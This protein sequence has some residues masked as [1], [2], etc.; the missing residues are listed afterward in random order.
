MKHLRTALGTALA[1]LV[2][3]ATPAHAI[4]FGQPDG[5]RHPSVGALLHDYDPAS[6]GPDV[7]CTGT[8]IAPK[9]FLTASHCTEGLDRVAVSFASRYDEGA[10]DP[11]GVIGG[12]AVTH[13]EYGTGGQ[14]DGHDIAV[15]LLDSAPAGI[16][17]AQ[18]PARRSLD[19]LKAAHA[20]DD[21]TFTA[22]GY[23]LVRD[24]KGG[25]SKELYD[26]MGERRFALQTSLSLRENWLLLSM[27]PATGDG[28]TCYGDSGGPHF[29]GGER[30]DRIVSITVTGDAV[31][32]ATDKTYRL[33]SDSAR[34]FLD[35][36]VTL[37]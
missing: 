17:P 20:L 24:T 21:Q 18:L 5:D 32:R 11:A 25:G 15:V 35:D 22:V 27:N 16:T 14:D 6:P 23:G 31:C 36:Y 9:V 29:L 10:A 7:M 26:P 19:R 13:P 3:T 30:S 28:G 12:R 8:L 4:T 33:D 34:A 2:V 37:P 1:A